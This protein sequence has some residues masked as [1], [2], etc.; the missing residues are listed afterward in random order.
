MRVARLPRD[1]I[2]RHNCYTIHCAYS[3]NNNI[4]ASTVYASAAD[5]S[6]DLDD[7]RVRDGTKRS[8]GCRSETNF[9]T[10]HSQV[11]SFALAP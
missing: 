1:L 2:G 8:S 9:S 3:G 4:T 11:S 7:G 5:E 10:S 6:D